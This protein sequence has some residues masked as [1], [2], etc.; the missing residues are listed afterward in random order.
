[1]F[2]NNLN[3]NMGGIS[4]AGNNGKIKKLSRFGKKTTSKY[5]RHLFSLDMLVI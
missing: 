3:V 4:K 5:F 1:M 2:K